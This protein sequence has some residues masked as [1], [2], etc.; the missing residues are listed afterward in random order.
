MTPIHPEPHFEDHRVDLS[1]EALPE[2]EEAEGEAAEDAL[3]RAHITELRRRQ[4]PG[5]GETDLF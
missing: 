2:S 4:C 5:C 1:G 3:W